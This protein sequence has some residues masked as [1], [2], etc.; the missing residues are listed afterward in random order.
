MIA[1]TARNENA[2]PVMRRVVVVEVA[3]CN[4]R[5]AY[6]SDAHDPPK[7]QALPRC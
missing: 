7:P 2:V 6:D 5:S 4:P 1:A 3:I